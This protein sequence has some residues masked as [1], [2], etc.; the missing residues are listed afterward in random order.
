MTCPTLEDEVF[1]ESSA[2][3]ESSELAVVTIPA[4]LGVFMEDIPATPAFAPTLNSTS[5][6]KRPLE[7]SPT[8]EE[9]VL[10]DT[11]EEEE[12]TMAS[13]TPAT[14]A[15]EEAPVSIAI[16]TPP[17]EEEEPQL[18]APVTPDTDIQTAEEEPLVT[19]PPP[20]PPMSPYVP[21]GPYAWA[22]DVTLTTPPPPPPQEPVRIRLRVNAKKDWK[23]IDVSTSE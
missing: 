4:P 13:V 17:A 11:E 7:T 20:H 14:N 12:E 19:P 10:C 6:R 21:R 16:Q 1:H 9:R 22:K 8:L 3:P 5:L 23:T 15:E 18:E 2:V